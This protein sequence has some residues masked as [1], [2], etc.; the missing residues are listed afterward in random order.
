LC[1]Y[2]QTLDKSPKAR[3][4][5][6]SCDESSSWAKLHLPKR[7]KE[8]VMGIAIAIAA[9][10]AI[11]LIASAIII[12]VSENMLN[13]LDEGATNLSRRQEA[14]DG[15]REVDQLRTN[16]RAYRKYAAIGF[17]ASL[18]ALYIVIRFWP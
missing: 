18:A 8:N 13:A 16:W 7:K 3:Y 9:F 1:F 15:L 4:D 10:L 5:W 11:V 6:Q 14:C 2:H 12:T 17:F